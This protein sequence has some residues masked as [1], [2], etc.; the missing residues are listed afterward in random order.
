[1][2]RFLVVGVLSL[3]IAPFAAAESHDPADYPL[4]LH[5]Y[6]R[7]EKNFY[8]RRQL[9]EVKGEGHGNLFEGGDPMGV[10]FQFDCDQ[11]LQTSTGFETFPAKWKKPGFELVI[12]Q[13]QFGK[14]GYDTCRLKVI[15]RDFVYRSRNGNLVTQPAVAFKQWMVAHQYDPERGKEDPLHLADETPWEGPASAMP[16]SAAPPR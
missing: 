15:V 3:L 4:R 16:G 12:L 11:K 6:R 14:P 13:P 10:D 2:R 5:I 1:M 9:E 8:H 7:N